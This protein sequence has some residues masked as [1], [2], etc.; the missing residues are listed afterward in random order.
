M[1]LK[2]LPL[3]R[4]WGQ[5]VILKA[6]FHVNYIPESSPYL[7]HYGLL[8]YKLKGGYHGFWSVL[9]GFKLSSLLMGK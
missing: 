3:Q 9:Y 1:W 6:A 2:K 5:I 4:R 8:R 7:K